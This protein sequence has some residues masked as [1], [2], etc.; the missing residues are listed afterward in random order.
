[1]T[2]R[3]R[4]AFEVLVLGAAFGVGWAAAGM[5]GRRD[6]A[7]ADLAV[8]ASTGASSALD[9]ACIDRHAMAANANLVEQVGDYRRRLDVA[10]EQAAGT[11]DAARSL[12]NE[13]PRRLVPPRDEW[14]RMAR[15]GTIRVRVPC[16][17]WDADG[18]FTVVGADGAAGTE[19]A[20]SGAGGRMA[21][22]GL[23]AEELEAL[24]ATYE[25]AHAKTWAA[26]RSTCEGSVA[27]RAYIDEH[28][29]DAELTDERRVAYCASS[30][31]DMREP[32][33]R[34][35]IGYVAQLRASGA[36]IE[37]AKSDE[38]R[39]AFALSNASTDLYREM[40]TTLGRDKATRAIENGVGCIEETVY[41][42]REPPA[43]ERSPQ[44]L[45]DHE[46]HDDD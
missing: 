46:G 7:R 40:V 26:M 19:A 9:D 15:D 45:D 4:H 29:Q 2:V 27:F 28:E 1:M 37:R 10:N 34:R 24:G 5:S 41:D 44:R 6:T 22:A 17:R 14:A 43:E 3:Q 30:F 38:Q 11:H 32:P 39:V 13:P 20:G 36:G 18:S 42:L 33:V 25:R 8:G 23:S 35:A 21:V 16:S 31:L 12:A